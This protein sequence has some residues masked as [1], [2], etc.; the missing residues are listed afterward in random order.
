MRAVDGGGRYCEAE[1]H[2]AVEDAN[3]NPPQFS[4]DPYTVTV[5][6]NTE[7][8]AYVAKLLATDLDAGE[9]SLNCCF[10]SFSEESSSS[11]RSLA[12]MKVPV[13]GHQR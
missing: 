10:C 4:S 5:F 3:D 8:G 6:E 12:L 1:V 7:M 11:V 9:L 13:K 2:V